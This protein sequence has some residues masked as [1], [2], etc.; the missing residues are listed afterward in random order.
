MKNH[1]LLHTLYSIIT[2]LVLP[3]VTADQTVKSGCR[4]LDCYQDIQIF[5]HR[6]Y[7]YTLPRLRQMLQGYYC[8]RIFMCKLSTDFVIIGEGLSKCWVHTGKKVGK[9][10]ARLQ[11]SPQN[12]LKH[13]AQETRLN[14]FPNRNFNA[15]MWAFYRGASVATQSISSIYC[16]LGD[17]LAISFTTDLSVPPAVQSSVARL[18]VKNVPLFHPRTSTIFMET[19]SD[20]TVLH[21]CTASY[22]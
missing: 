8:C 16:N 7:K 21:T 14:L 15:W 10:I 1:F 11:Q 20:H 4:A 3:T 19:Y 6:L 5:C 2:I 18:N 13:L 22:V 12:T 9:I 17:I